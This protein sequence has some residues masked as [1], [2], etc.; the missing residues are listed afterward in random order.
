MRLHSNTTFVPTFT[1]MTPLTGVAL[2]VDMDEPVM[3]QMEAYAA[4]REG[5][6]HRYLVMAVVRQDA[7][8]GF[9]TDLGLRT[10]YDSEHEGETYHQPEYQQPILLEHNVGECLEMAEQGRNEEFAT[11]RLHEQVM[12]TDMRA[13]YQQVVEQ[14]MNLIKNRSS[15]GPYVRIERNGYSPFGKKLQQEALEERND[16]YRTR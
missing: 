12:S 11:K 3:W 1:T 5:V 10:D 15:F 4:N 6:V 7:L 13:R 14:D 2:D 8:S 9:W 16:Y